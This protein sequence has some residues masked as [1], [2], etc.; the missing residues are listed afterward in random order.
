MI[1]EKNPSGLVQSPRPDQHPL[2]EVTFYHHLHYLNALIS[3]YRT[4]ETGKIHYITS[5][6]AS[7]LR[8]K[9]PTALTIATANC[10]LKP[11]VSAT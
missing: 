4:S 7:R 10:G 2:L 6:H 5:P 1:S 3:K 9:Q 8:R 11:Q